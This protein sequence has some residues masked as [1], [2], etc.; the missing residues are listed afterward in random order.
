MSEK[1]G[2][3]VKK[4][5]TGVERSKDTEHD[6]SSDLLSDLPQSSKTSPPEPSLPEVAPVPKSETAP[7]TPPR[8]PQ[9]LR[10]SSSPG[11][12][13]PASQLHGLSGI[14]GSPSAPFSPGGLGLRLQRSISDMSAH[15]IIFNR[16]PSQATTPSH[17]RSPS[18][19]SVQLKNTTLVDDDLDEE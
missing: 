5:E 2:D 15:R 7:P 9:P 18:V 8:P 1:D 11:L 19:A 10:A 14:S 13:S 3:G 17:S 4:E 12:S 16:S 6:E